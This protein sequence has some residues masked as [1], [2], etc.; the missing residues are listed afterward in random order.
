M[1]FVRLS[2]RPSEPCGVAR[3]VRWG[4]FR[5]FGDDVCACLCVCAC[6][7]VCVCMSGCPCMLLRV[8]RVL[9]C[10]LIL[11]QVVKC[12]G[13]STQVVS[14]FSFPLPEVSIISG[15]P[16][17]VA[18]AN[19]NLRRFLVRA[20]DPLSRREA[21][22]HFVVVL[23]QWRGDCSHC[24]NW[25]WS[26]TLVPDCVAHFHSDGYMNSPLRLPLGCRWQIIPSVGPRQNV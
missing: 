8:S 15:K 4:R 2:V 1:V 19:L 10:S 12:R 9:L 5:V 6:V 13:L 11:A 26:S 17:E 24:M 22:L 21:A 25:W 20:R 18:K 23:C 16:P 3:M 7:C 14:S